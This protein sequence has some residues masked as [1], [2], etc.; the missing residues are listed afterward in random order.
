[1]CEYLFKLVLNLQ[2]LKLKITL[3]IIKYLKIYYYY[4]YVHLKKNF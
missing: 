4:K 3:F 1:M 2:V